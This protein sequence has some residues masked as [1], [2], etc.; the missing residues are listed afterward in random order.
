MLLCPKIC[1]IGQFSQPIVQSLVKVCLLTC[2]HL[3][4][5]VSLIVPE[6]AFAVYNCT[7]VCDKARR[8]LRQWAADCLE[9]LIASRFIA[10]FWLFQQATFKKHLWQS[11]G[12]AQVRIPSIPSRYY[13]QDYTSLAPPPRTV[14][15]HYPGKLYTLKQASMASCHTT[16]HDIYGWYHVNTRMVDRTTALGIYFRHFELEKNHTQNMYI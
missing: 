8:K 12:V 16:R 1:P 2:L 6:E 4:K 11:C 14:L 13:R 10:Q 9:G 3:R 7:A 5:Q 15:Q